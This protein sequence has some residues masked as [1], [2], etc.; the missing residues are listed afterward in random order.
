V[1]QGLWA[2]F[3]LAEL[4][5]YFLELVPAPP[6][7]E[8][9]GP[10]PC[11]G[12][13]TIDS[14]ALESLF[15]GFL[16][17]LAHLPPDP[18]DLGIVR[19]KVLQVHGIQGPDLVGI[20]Q[21]TGPPGLPWRFGQEPLVHGRREE[22]TPDAVGRIGQHGIGR[23][24]NEFPSMFPGGKWMVGQGI[25]GMRLEPVHGQLGI[26]AKGAGLDL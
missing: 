6:G 11:G 20:P 16:G 10:V 3:L 25:G 1:A 15:H 14:P 17:L 18:L 19:R 22:V 12:R 13:E 21:E 9:P 24:E 7:I 8:F 5:P 26:L 4:P 23:M 2:V